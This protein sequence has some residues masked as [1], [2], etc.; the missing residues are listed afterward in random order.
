MEVVD[1]QRWNGTD[2]LERSEIARRVTVVE[3]ESPLMSRVLA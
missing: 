2:N 3:G 1:V